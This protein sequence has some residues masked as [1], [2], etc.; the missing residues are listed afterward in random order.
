VGTLGLPVPAEARSISVRVGPSGIAATV[1]ADLRDAADTLHQVVLGETGA[2]RGALRGRLPTGRRGPWEL[3]ALELDEPAGLQATNGHQNGE[4]VAAG[5]QA[6]GTVTLGAMSF[7]DGAS[8]AISTHDPAAWRAVGAASDPRPA[9]NAVRVAFTDSGQPGIVRPRQP[10]DTR[11]VPVLVDPSTAAA[12]GAGGTLALTVDGEPVS[13]RV[14][15]VLR[16]FPTIPAGSAG[17]VVADEQTLAGALDAQLLGQG[18]A[19]ELWIS[20]RDLAPLR[21]ALNAPHLSSLE[22][23]YR[24]TIE[25]GLRDAPVARAVLGTLIAAAALSAALAIVGL[26]AALLGPGRDERME[27]DLVDQG[28]SPRAVCAQLRLE[29]VIASALGVVAGAAIALVLARLAVDTIRAVAALTTGA[30]PLITVEPVG[31]LVLWSAAGLAALAIAT[32]LSTAGRTRGA[33]S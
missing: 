12:A 32:W 7:D 8:R 5:T 23:Q 10:S 24:R 29:A 30:P 16:R 21:A 4:N 27:S 1:T 25:S 19:D 33:R 3:G 2:G 28:A 15:G 13:A 14:A 31:E 6:S 9:G 22:A 18:R 11:P 20:T 26:L 17:F